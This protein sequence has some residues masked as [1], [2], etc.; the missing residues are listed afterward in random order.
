MPQPIAL[1]TGG[2]SGI[3]LALSYRFARAGY[4]LLWVG[5]DATEMQAASATFEQDHPTTLIDQF[6]I[7]LSQPTAAGQVHRWA[8]DR[9]EAVDVLINN[10]GFGTS[11]YLPEIDREREQ[12]MIRLNVSTL[13]ELSTRF[14]EDMLARNS[15]H[16]IN[17]ASISAFQAC[18]YLT[19]YAA[20]KAF[21]KNFSEGLNYELKAK[22]SKVRV[23]AVCPP[24]VRTGFAAA[25]KMEDS[26]LFDSWMVVTAEQVANATFRAMQKGQSVVV[27]GRGFSLLNSIVTRFPM[28]WR[29]AF[30]AG[31]I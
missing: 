18:P 29:V 8:N 22:K 11:G 13:H 9:G 20:T 17:L 12:T 4:R 10:A 3:G 16:I 30:A 15:G 23:T 7:D 24:P 21:V 1:I 25:A 31:N 5:I 19:T 28:S 14:L 27:P 26:K 6:I 2:S